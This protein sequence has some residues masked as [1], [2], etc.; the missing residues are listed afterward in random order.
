M[1]TAL[2]LIATVSAP[3]EI[4]VSTM[5]SWVG[6]GTLKFPVNL[7]QALKMA[8]EERRNSSRPITVYLRG[9]VYPLE[10]TLKLDKALTGMPESPTTFAAYGGA[11]VVLSGGEDVSPPKGRPR[12]SGNYPGSFQYAWSVD[13]GGVWSKRIPRIADLN[14]LFSNGIRYRRTRL[15][16]TG[17]YTISD[18]IK[19]PERSTKGDY[20]IRS[21]PGEFDPMWHNL[22]DVETLLF[23]NWTITRL[24]ILGVNSTV[25]TTIFRGATLGAD[26]ALLKPGGRFLIENVKEALKKPGQFY[27]DRADSKLYVIPEKGVKLDLART[28]VP[29]LET[30]L[31]VDGASNIQ[32]KGITFSHSAWTMPKAGRNFPQAEADLGGAVVVQNAKNVSFDNCTISH[33]GGYGLEIGD[34]SQD[35]SFRNG[36]LSDLGAGGVKIG[37]MGPRTDESDV[38]QRV[39]IENNLIAGGGRVHPAAVGVWIGQSPHNVIKGNEIA[40]FYYTGVSI[41]WTWGYGLSNAHHNLIEGNHIYKIGQGVLSDMGGIYHL[42]IAPGTVL[43]GNRIHDISSFDYGGWGL[44]TDED[45]IV[46]RCSRQSFHQHYGKDNIVRRNILAFAG[47]SQLARTRDE[48]HRSF[49]LENNLVV[50]KGTPLL[51]GNW[52]GDASKAALDHNLYWRTDGQPI[53]FGDAPLKDWQ[54]RGR[55]AHSIIADP[56]FVDASKDDFRL[57]PGSPAI[58]LGFKAMDPKGK[59]WKTRWSMPEPSYPVR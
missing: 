12:L 46:Y 29:R 11:Q 27:F 21:K 25:N 47:E 2:I 24:P 3:R 58:A 33:T 45:N 17:F 37:V 19:D 52:N 28:I 4:F 44:Y 53:L 26:W 39:T 14:Q 31:K 59:P 36:E 51:W 38:T 23:Q 18:V 15:P 1:F 43:R 20:Q 32:F 34:H 40:D 13:N 57:K 7:D 50:W 30:I 55:D 10:A 41:G 48:D 42:G 35:I 56:L 49:T 22:Q 8:A 54:A 5:G 6:K 16:E 9:G